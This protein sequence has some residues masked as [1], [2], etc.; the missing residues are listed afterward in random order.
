MLRL[1]L[2]LF[3]IC[4]NFLGFSQLQGIVFGIKNGAKLPVNKAKVFLRNAGVH[5]YTE[6]NGRFELVLPKTLPDYLVVTAAGYES[7]SVQVTKEDRFSGIEIYL[8]GEDELDEVVIEFKRDTKGFSRLN[9]LQVENLGEGELKKAACCN[10]SE[11]FETNATVDVNFTDAVSGAKKIQLL[12]LDGIYSQMQMENI[13]FL[14][15]LESGFGLSAIPGTWVESI[16]ITKGTGSVVNGYESM[17]G[18]INVEF[19]KPQTMQRLFVNGYVNHLG[20]GE[21]N[22]HGGQIINKKWSTGTFVHGSM[23]QTPWDMNK[24][25]FL[26]VPLSKTLSLL[27][28]WEYNGDKFESRFGVSAYYDERSGGQLKGI[29]NRYQA[30]TTNKHVEFFAKTG[31][32][33][34]KIPHN[35]L[36]IVYQFKYHDVDGI[37]GLRKFGGQELRGY[38]NAIYDGIFGTTAHKYKTGISFVGQDLKQYID[39]LPLNRSILT[40]GVFF[41]YTYTHPRVV[42]VAGVRGDYVSS[43]AGQ[44]DRFQFSPRIHTKFVLDE[45]TDLRLT[46][47]KSWRLP[48]VVMDN[49][50]L[51][52]TSKKWYV[53]NSNDYEVVWNSGV[54]LI[55]SMR[56][57]NRQAS[58][59]ADFYHARFTR[60]MIVDRERSVDSIYFGFQSNLTYSSTLQ[61]E[62]SF[63]P[64]KTITM[65]FAYK[66]LDV[67]AKYAGAMKQQVMIPNHRG[68]FNIAY[69]SRNKKW[70]IDATISVYSKVRLPDVMLPDGTKLEN[71]KGQLVPV[72]LA[73]ITHHFKHVDVYVGGENLFN[74][75]QKNP[76]ISA[77]NPYDPTFDATR[78]WA[79]VMGAVVYAGFRFEINRKIEKK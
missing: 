57:F 11:S 74:F 67:K 54:S 60:Q 28:R 29:V 63:M 4:I 10:L 1:I 65:R 43:F 45:Y 19:R 22:L 30:N 6:E 21:L 73:Q 44:K 50:S 37:Y 61:A 56:I 78:V 13:P 70:E 32:M 47:G 20:R 64:W 31:F 46:T 68:L 33:F 34:P 71:Q 39:S 35:S 5:V 79:P 3:F 51:F 8:I 14:T 9:P 40:P 27:N 42:V 17:A 62:F 23:L 75:K 25:K 24:D 16:Q 18:L 38:V 49:S 48:T 66:Y 36:G 59:S 53:T 41:E 55:R 26:D 15:G 58:V 7:D 72:G 77:N 69:A 52:A 2:I 76:I 12:G